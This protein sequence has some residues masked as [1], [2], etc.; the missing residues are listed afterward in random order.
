M[1][2]PTSIPLKSVN[3]LSAWFTNTVLP[4]A[5]SLGVVINAVGGLR[6]RERELPRSPATWRCYQRYWRAQRPGPPNAN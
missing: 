3:S 6:F 1:E 5:N 2:H 4:L